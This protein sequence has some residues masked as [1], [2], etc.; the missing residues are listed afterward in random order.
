MSEVSGKGHYEIVG[1]LINN[2]RFNCIN[3]KDENSYTALHWGE[4]LN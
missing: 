1:I 2:E 3:E 4:Y